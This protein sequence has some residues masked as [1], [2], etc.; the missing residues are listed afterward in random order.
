MNTQEFVQGKLA[1]ARGVSKRDNPYQGQYEL[2]TTRPEAQCKLDW[3]K[4]WE[5]EKSR[6]L[7]EY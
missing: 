4:G 1:C 3:D 2:A 7:V 6:Q 5:A